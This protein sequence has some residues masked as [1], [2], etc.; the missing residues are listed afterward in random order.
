MPK[1]EEMNWITRHDWIVFG[2]LARVAMP[3]K[4]PVNKSRFTTFP[5]RLGWRRQ[6]QKCVCVNLSPS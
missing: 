3:V 6:T 2:L 5:F 4:K 1:N